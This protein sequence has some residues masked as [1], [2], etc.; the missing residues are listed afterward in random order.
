MNDQNLYELYAAAASAQL[1]LRQLLSHPSLDLSP[2]EHLEHEQV[3][4]RLLR[5]V[6]EV[7]GAVASTAA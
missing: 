3:M 1:S 6:R 7:E 2:S 4:I 5:I